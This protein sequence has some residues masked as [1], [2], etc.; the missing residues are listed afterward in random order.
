MPIRKHDPKDSPHVHL[1]PKQVLSGEYVTLTQASKSLGGVDLRT[2]RNWIKQLHI[3]TFASPND[4]RV[5]MI[6]KDDMGRLAKITDRPLAVEFLKPPSNEILERQLEE[7]RARYMRM[8]ED[9]ER[10]LAEQQATYTLAVEDYERQL[11]ALRKQLTDR[12]P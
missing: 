9:Y 8:V 10:Q 7:L 1:R 3:K 4:G 2:L 5:I 6:H 11:A 12:S